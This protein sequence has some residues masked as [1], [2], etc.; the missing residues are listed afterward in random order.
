DRKKWF[1]NL[2]YEISANS[3]VGAGAFR[4]DDY[5]SVSRELELR[6]PDEADTWKDHTL[7][8]RL[9]T[10]VKNSSEAEFKAEFHK[11]LNKEFV[12]KYFVQVLTFGMIDNLGKNLMINTWDGLVWYPSFYDMDTMLG[13]DNTGQIRIPTNAE[14]KSGLWNTSNSL[15]WSK[16]QKVF[17]KEIRALYAELRAKGKPYDYDVLMS[18]YEG[19][20]VSKIAQKYYNDDAYVKYINDPDGRNKY[21]YACHGSRL[22]FTKKWIRE[23]LLFMDTLMGYTGSSVKE[24]CSFRA[25]KQG[26]VTLRLKTYS[27]MY[28][29]VNFAATVGAQLT[30]MC[31]P[32]KYT[33]FEWNLLTGTDQEVNITCAPHLKEIEGLKDFRPSTIL[34]EKATR[35]TSID[36]SESAFLKQASLNGMTN[37]RHVDFSNCANLG[38][39]IGGDTVINVSSC[40]NLKTLLLNNTQ[41]TGVTLLNGGGY[42]NINISNTKVREFKVGNMAYL[43]SL[44]LSGCYNLESVEVTNCNKIRTLDLQGNKATK[45]VIDRCANIEQVNLDNNSGLSQLSITNSP[46]VRLVSLANIQAKSYNTVDLQGCTG[47]EELNLQDSKYIKEVIFNEYP[48]DDCKLTTILATNSGITSCKYGSNDTTSDGL[49]FRKASKI[50]NVKL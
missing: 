9:I 45:V 32:D 41:I 3:D 33:D 30:Y 48:N 24:E 39:L 18:V 27:P 13:L 50:N 28:V 4:M 44:G 25:N 19:E 6:F 29:T 23:R 16:V 22:E 47:L 42:K 26:K 36:C 2:S 38:T 7:I 20:I 34:L 40:P 14:I 12:I 37:L 21:L 46:K 35:L 43:D 1:E 5:E 15:L 17:D 31:G 11:Y 10:W 49:D 8:R